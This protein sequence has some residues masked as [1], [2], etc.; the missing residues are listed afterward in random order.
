MKKEYIIPLLIIATF[1]T[2]GIYARL[3]TAPDETISKV[4]AAPQAG[5]PM[6]A[7][8]NPGANNVSDQY[9]NQVQQLKSYL[10][11]NPDDTTHLLRL[12]RLYQDGHN[13]ELATVYYER[14]VKLKPKDHQSWLDL[15][16][17]YATSGDWIKAKKTTLALLDNFPGDEEGTYNLGA[18]QANTGNVDE[19]KQL[20]MQLT[21]SKKSKIAQLA[22]KS[23][24][25]LEHPS[26]AGN[27]KPQ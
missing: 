2:F 4:G 6:T 14:L 15:T 23:L 27:D 13:P 9:K 5:M 25:Q 20:W 22:T 10:T 24:Q 17:C 21:K 26:T 8:D 11:D 12:A 7:P 16:N 1:V 3:P 19:A 18:I